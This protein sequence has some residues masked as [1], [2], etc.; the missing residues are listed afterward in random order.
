MIRLSLQ[1]LGDAGALGS[2]DHSDVTFNPWH[3]RQFGT[4]DHK[5]NW[6][7]WDIEEVYERSRKGSGLTMTS[8]GRVTPGDYRI[9]DGWGRITWGGD[10]N[11]VMACDRHNARLFDIRVRIYKMH[12]G[13]L[14]FAD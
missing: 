1:P 9:A 10:L 14:G 8:N 12:S 2:D 6:G 7:V 4:L 11:S 5:G 13:F 3:D